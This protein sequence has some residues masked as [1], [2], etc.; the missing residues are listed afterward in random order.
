MDIP[1]SLRG[2]LEHCEG[3][4]RNALRLQSQAAG[5]CGTYVTSP[6]KFLTNAVDSTMQ[7]QKNMVVGTVRDAYQCRVREIMFS[8][9][10]NI[11]HFEGDMTLS[12]M[13]L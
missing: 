13:F 3:G 4:V 6:P 9:R 8:Q 1:P 2:T 12:M 5:M 7:P 10:Q 11:L